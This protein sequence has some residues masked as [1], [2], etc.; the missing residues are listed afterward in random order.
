[1]TPDQVGFIAKVAPA[2]VKA[3]QQTG[4]PASITIAQCILESGWGKT[5]LASLHNNFFGI[6]ATKQDIAEGH[7]V[8]Y[9]TNE[10]VD[11]KLEP[12]HAFF[13]TYPSFFDCFAEHARLLTTP[14]YERAMEVKDDTPA[15][16]AALGPK[17]EGCGYSTAHNYG[18]KLMEIVRLY[19][20]EKYRVSSPVVQ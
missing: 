9:V 17:P 12:E 15:F 13:D 6:K 8:E 11:G 5:K 2:A 3:E 20:L 1:M 16:A 10:E 7:Y 19:D 4:V 18:D 14:N